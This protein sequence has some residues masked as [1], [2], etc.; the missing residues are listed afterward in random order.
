MLFTFVIYERLEKSYLRWPLVNGAQTYSPLMRTWTLRL[1]TFLSLLWRF[2]KRSNIYIVFN[3]KPTLSLSVSTLWISF[4]PERSK[5][6]LMKTQPHSLA[7]LADMFPQTRA[8][9]RWKKKKLNPLPCVFGTGLLPALWNPTQDTGTKRPLC[10]C[11]AQ[12]RLLLSQGSISTS[13][14]SFH[15]AQHWPFPNTHMR[16]FKTHACSVRWVQI[17][18][19]T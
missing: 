6:F 5:G 13:P 11:S 16:H 9:E 12:G 19:K 7:M 14:C 2:C 4:S 15:S 10:C 1:F 18:A 3:Q 8:K 17:L